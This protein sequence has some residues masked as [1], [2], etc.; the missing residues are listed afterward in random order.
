MA[1]DN[2]ENLDKVAASYRAAAAARSVSDEAQALL[3]SLRARSQPVLAF[4]EDKARGAVPDGRGVVFTYKTA[5]TDTAILRARAVSFTAGFARTVPGSD[6]APQ[7]GF[8][9]SAVTITFTHHEH[10]LPTVTV[11]WHRGWPDQDFALRNDTGWYKR[12]P[13]PDDGEGVAAFTQALAQ[14]AQRVAV[15]APGQVPPPL[16]P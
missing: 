3:A 15:A 1:G 12:G 2:R 11:G 16:H 8:D 9:D 13:F 7:L 4:L 14:L 10:R 5:E 6:E